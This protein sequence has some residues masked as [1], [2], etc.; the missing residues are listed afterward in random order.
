[1]ISGIQS[2]LTSLQAFSTRLENTGNNIANMNTDGFKKGRVLLAE[3]PQGGVSARAEK[4]DQPGP[5][6]AE[7]TSAGYEMVE[8]SNV[9]PGEEIPD[10]I[11]STR[12][13]EA[14]LK[15]LQAG[16]EMS[17]TLLDIRG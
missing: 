2:A 12:A 6:V 1:M 13:Y 5:V 4:V 3:Q 16:D 11:R 15:T 8:Q 10:M 7:Q 17:S 9:D 14:N